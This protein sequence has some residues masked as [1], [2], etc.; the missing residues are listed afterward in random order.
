MREVSDYKELLRI[1]N[2]HKVRYL[3]IGAYAVIYYTEPRYTKDLDIWVDPE[4]Q[5]AQKTYEALKEFGAPLTNIAPAD[6]TKKKTIYQIG[7]A[8]VRVDILMG[9]PGLGFSRAWDH[10]VM[11]VYDEVR[12]SIIGLEEL[13]KSKKKAGR[14]S[15][16]IDITQLQYRVK[17]QIKNTRRLK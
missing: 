10:R 6:F 4:E 15:D 12:V 14:P 5:N 13:I 8:P 2:K 1:L 3:V 7:V 16:M 17:L 9:L 11:T